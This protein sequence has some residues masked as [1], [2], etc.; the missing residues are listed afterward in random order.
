M[1]SAFELFI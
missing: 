1:I